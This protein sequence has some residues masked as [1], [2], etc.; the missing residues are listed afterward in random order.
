MVL[1]LSMTVFALR[2]WT[3]VAPPAPMPAAVAATAT[4]EDP[5]ESERN[6]KPTSKPTSSWVSV[7]E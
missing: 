3:G 4:A 5:P 7:D 2:L 6:P 1:L